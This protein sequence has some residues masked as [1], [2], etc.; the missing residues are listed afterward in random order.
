[1]ISHGTVYLLD[2]D[3][4]MTSSVQCLLDSSGLQI[5]VYKAVRDFLNQLCADA[6]GCL[7]T[8]IRMPMVSGLQVLNELK[9]RKSDLSVIFLTSCV[10]I[11]VAI[12]A[13]KNGAI[14][15]ITKPFSEQKLID[16]VYSAIEISQNKYKKT[17]RLKQ[18]KDCIQLLSKRE[19]EVLECLASGM[20]NKLI[21][22]RLHISKK[23]VEMHRANV[24]RKM[25][26]QNI[27]ELVSLYTFY[28]LSL[29]EITTHC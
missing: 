9:R 21:S 26:V 10:D 20:I 23:T 8:D 16:S 12:E 3:S 5:Y 6:H 1:V 19:Y 22:T 13:L 29:A 18:I 17:S 14:E 24:M 15:Y 7:I 28:Q 2:C 11:S 25:Q 27:A 4:K